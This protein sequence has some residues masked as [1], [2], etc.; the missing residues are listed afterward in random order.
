M[1]DIIAGMKKIKGTFC[2]TI[3]SLILISSTHAVLAGESSLDRYGD[4][5]GDGFSNYIEELFGTDPFDAGSRPSLADNHDLIKASW[6]LIDDAVDV[7]GSGIE[8]ALN[9]GAAFRSHGVAPRN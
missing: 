5:D 7:F 1:S 6:P 9:G 4:A 2:A 8:G 3:F